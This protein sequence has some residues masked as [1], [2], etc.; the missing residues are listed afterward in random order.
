MSEDKRPHGYEDG[1]YGGDPIQE[2][3]ERVRRS[4][5]RM[6]QFMRWMN[7]APNRGWSQELKTRVVIH[8]GEI[9]CSGPEVTFGEMTAAA[10]A[11]A[12]RGVIKVYVGSNYWG[13]IHV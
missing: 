13:N 1:K 6:N 5:T 11:A 9:L 3:V 10:N 4:E 7:F 8:E 12:L 2:I